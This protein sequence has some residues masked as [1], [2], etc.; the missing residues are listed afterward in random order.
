MIPQYSFVFNIISNFKKFKILIILEKLRYFFLKKKKKQKAI[1]FNLQILEK[2]LLIEL[3]LFRRFL[4]VFLDLFLDEIK[5]NSSMLIIFLQL[6]ILI[7]VK[8]Y[9][10]ET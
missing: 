10:E 2:D 3:R 9:R 7:N 6:V 8:H 1:L 4:F 5:Q